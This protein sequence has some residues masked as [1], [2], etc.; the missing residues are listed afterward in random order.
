MPI[1][2]R[3]IVK[4]RSRRGRGLTCTALLLPH[5]WGHIDS[6][7]GTCKINDVEPFA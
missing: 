3:Y 2:C 4:A 6:L 5:W 1:I 7:I